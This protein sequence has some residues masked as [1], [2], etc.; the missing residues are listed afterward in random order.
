MGSH[1]I[2]VRFVFVLRDDRLFKLNR[3]FLHVFILIVGLIT[4][5]QVGK[6]NRGKKVLCSQIVL[7][8]LELKV[9]DIVVA[10]A[11]GLVVGAFEHLAGLGQFDN[12]EHVRHRQET[13]VRKLAVRDEGLKQIVQVVDLNRGAVLVVLQ[14]AQRVRVHHVAHPLVQHAQRQHQ[15]VDRLENAYRRQRE[16]HNQNEAYKQI[17]PNVATCNKLYI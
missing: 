4:E 9:R 15:V 14:L 10:D 12:S 1:L 11:G 16:N 7:S 17:L 13:V 2:V 5:A 6:L 8:V 3:R